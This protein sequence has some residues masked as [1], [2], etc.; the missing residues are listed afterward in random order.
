MKRT[1]TSKDN[2]RSRSKAGENL[3]LLFM[4]GLKSIYWAEKELVNALTHMS[5][6]AL[7]E[8]LVEVLEKHTTETQA[9][10]E[11]V[12]KVFE[13]LE[14]SPEANRCESMEGLIREGEA[15]IESLE[16]GPV[17]DAAIIAA[18]Q[19]V[20]HYEIASYGTLAAY[21]DL[22]QYG[23]VKNILGEILE[24]EKMADEKLTNAAYNSVNIDAAENEINQEEE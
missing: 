13:L 21:A 1:T 18:A 2:L 22:L 24:E 4:E 11:K 19:K 3:N 6:N 9:Q 17:R 15:V 12:E 5:E 7:D 14:E 10:V 8:R 23:E 20:E 16:L